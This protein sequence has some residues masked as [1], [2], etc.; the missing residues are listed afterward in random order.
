MSNSIKSFDLDAAFR[1]LDEIEMPKVGKVLPNRTNLTETFKRTDKMEALL[2]DYYDVNDTADMEAASDEREAEINKAKLA[3]IEKIVDL[4]AQSIDELAPSYAGKT[5]LQCP[6]CMTLFYKSPEDVE[7][8]ENDPTTANVNEACQHCGNVS[9][10]TIVGK[11]APVEQDEMDNF[12]SEEKPTEETEEDNDLD[13]DFEEP[14]EEEGAA[15][16]EGEEEAID[17]E[18]DE[19][20]FDD[21]DLDFEEPE[22]EE[23][24]EEKKEESFNQGTGSPLNE[25]VEED[26][27]EEAEEEVVLEKPMKEVEEVLNSTPELTGRQIEEIAV[28]AAQEVKED[29]LTDDEITT[30]ENTVVKEIPE[31]VESAEAEAEEIEVADKEA[32]EIE[33][34][35][36]ACEGPDCEDKIEE[37]IDGLVSAGAGGEGRDQGTQDLSEKIDG[38]VS[39]GAGGENRDEGTQDLKECGENCEVKPEDK[40]EEKIDGL[41]SAGAGGE[42]REEGTQDL[43]E[44]RKQAIKESIDKLFE[45]SPEL[46][47]PIEAKQYV[48]GE[49]TEVFTELPDYKVEVEQKGDKIEVEL[50]P[51]TTEA[52]PEEVA[53]VAAPV[54]DAQVVAEVPVIVVD[55]QPVIGESLT[56]DADIK[57][58]FN[59]TDAEANELFN[60]T[61]FKKPIDDSEAIQDLAEEPTEVK[62][63]VEPQGEFS[64]AAI[65]ARLDAIFESCEGKD[66]SVEEAFEDCEDCDE[67]TIEEC[68]SESLKNVYEN[69]SSFTMSDCEIADGKLMVEGIIRFN[70]GNSKVTKY[71]FTEAKKFDN[72]IEFK[73]INESLNA[74]EI[75]MTASINAGKM[76]TE[77]IEYKY[78][79]KGHL[80]EGLAKRS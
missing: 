1:A 38:L 30:I 27:E 15:E 17:K 61:E 71:T 8:D 41:V 5:I 2:E 52:K 67:D 6:N 33:A 21:F 45:S 42:G 78:D 65:K 37:K 11:V 51:K 29:D 35:E 24:D 62:E 16:D 72:S 26:K 46:A 69:V 68:V 23:E 53:P 73:G 64:R 58:D 77:S 60:S 49:K 47:Q 63:A 50:E 34:V 7:V 14:V 4:D 28:D 22:E 39:A 56:E 48:E 18:S 70:S 25:A 79:I 54:E 12:E 32:I 80:V 40:I 76:F 74:K 55:E 19:D 3:R 44:S 57:A 36:E 20:N 43:K 13:L 10:Y 66:C 75:T 31:K 59:L 9:G